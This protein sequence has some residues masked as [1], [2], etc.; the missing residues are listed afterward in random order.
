MKTFEEILALTDVEIQF[1]IE[2]AER[3]LVGIRMAIA[4]DQE[5]DSS[6]R[7]KH[8]TYIAQLKTARRQRELGFAQKK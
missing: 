5:K 8:R 1:E 2:K 7:R 3:E 4:A 6:K